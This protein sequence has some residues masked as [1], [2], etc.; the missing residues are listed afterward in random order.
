MMSGLKTSY[1]FTKPEMLFLL[2]NVHD[3]SPSFPMK[4]I[5][6]EY[7]S[8]SVAPQEA[9]DGLAYKK[10]ISKSSGKVSLEP[11]TNLL[12]RSALS[13]RK[14]WIIDDNDAN[15]IIILKSESM[16][17]HIKRYLLIDGAWR[18]APYK[19]VAEITYEFGDIPIKS[20]KV[21]DNA[22]ERTYITPHNDFSWL[23]E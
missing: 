15:R 9:I 5:I 14:I 23:E 21:I 7:L 3:I 4:Y 13:T 10:L 6:N 11:V 8:D 1:I 12:A 2:S 19:N 18:I 16:F 17:M 20:V 22:G